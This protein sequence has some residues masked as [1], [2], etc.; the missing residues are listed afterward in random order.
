[1]ES[2]QHKSVITMKYM[3]SCWTKKI[4]R[5]LSASCRTRIRNWYSN[6]FCREQKDFLSWENGRGKQVGCYCLVLGVHLQED[7]E[8]ILLFCSFVRLIICVL[9]QAK[10]KGLSV[11]FLDG[12]YD[13]D[14]FASEN[15]DASRYYTKADISKLKELIHAW[16]GDIDVMLT[17]EWP[18]GVL[19][20]V[21]KDAL[22]GMCLS[23]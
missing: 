10:I 6:A 8:I 18:H 21:A 20:G 13:A 19:N 12:V 7:F 23:H 17:C 3:I 22:E 11:A 15:G 9:I 4:S 14:G 2:G 16:E 5:H 1:M